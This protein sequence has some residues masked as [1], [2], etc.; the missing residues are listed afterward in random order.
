MTL[1]FTQ[2]IECLLHATPMQCEDAGMNTDR[3]STVSATA[4]TE[5]P[6]GHRSREYEVEDVL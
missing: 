2:I 1:P 6:D 4:E 3:H 5:G